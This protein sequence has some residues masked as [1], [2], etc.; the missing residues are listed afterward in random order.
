MPIIGYSL[1]DLDPGTV[2]HIHVFKTYSEPMA[3]SGIFKTVDTLSQFQ[4]LLTITASFRHY[5]M[6]ILNLLRAGSDIFR[7]LAYLGT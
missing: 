4:T 5:F 2:R 3:Y 6:H 1:A 7:T